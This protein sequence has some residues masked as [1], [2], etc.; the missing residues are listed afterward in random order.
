MSK[1]TTVWLCLNNYT[2][3]ILDLI[4]IIII[5]LLNNSKKGLTMAIGVVTSIGFSRIYKIF[6]FHQ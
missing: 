1:K 2:H 5:I 3:R 4:I 6:S